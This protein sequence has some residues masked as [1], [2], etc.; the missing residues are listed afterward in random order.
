LRYALAVLLAL[1]LAAQTAKQPPA[2]LAVP[3][4]LKKEREAEAMAP[5]PLLGD[6]ALSDALGPP[7]AEPGAWVEYAVRTKGSPD[8]RV[9]ISIL[10]PAL[11]G[12]WYWLEEV[13]VGNDGMASAV[14]LRAHGDPSDTR[15]YDR[16]YLYVPGQAPIEVPLD[17]IPRAEPARQKPRKVVRG[18]P[19]RVKVMAGTFD[20]AQ[21]M[22]T[23]DLRIWRVE[24]VPLWG[25]VKAQTPRQSV[26]LMN[27]GKTG[28]HSTFPPGFSDDQNQGKGSDKVK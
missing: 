12:G 1:I 22:R 18:A 13:S 8:A 3:E 10:P 6:S 15:N 4:Q 5:A 24:S 25:V 19:E 27:S 17:Q 21:P 9:R 14:K 11:E 26:E 16:M 20:K 23:G 7:R 2:H 28:A